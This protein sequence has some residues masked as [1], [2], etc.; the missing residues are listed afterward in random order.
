MTR[1]LRA[2]MVDSIRLLA[3][4]CREKTTLLTSLIRPHDGEEQF[5][6]KHMMSMETDRQTPSSI[7]NVGTFAFNVGNRSTGEGD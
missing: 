5:R 7:L 4:S 6:H 2:N 3:T 1:S